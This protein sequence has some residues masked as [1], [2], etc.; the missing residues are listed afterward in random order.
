MTQLA[1]AQGVQT[2]RET[3]RTTPTRTSRLLGCGVVAAP[4]FV[5]ASL[6]QALTRDGFDLNRHPFSMLSLG[7][8][9]WIQIANFVT[10]GSLFVAA[11][12]GMRQVLRGGRGGTWGPLLIGCAGVSMI[13]G[14]VFLADPALGFPA[15]APVGQPDVV[16]WQGKVHGLAFALGMLALIAAYV[17]FTV[18]FATVKQRGWAAYSAAAGVAF[19][20]LGVLGMASGEYRLLAVAIAIGWGWIAGIAMRL[21]TQLLSR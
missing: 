14:G 21:R 4:L 2:P 8:L 6:T 15:G 19:V 13:A 10:S 11:A 7:D 20:T 5:V 12:V 3:T 18:R 16:S 17:V 1:T 9:G